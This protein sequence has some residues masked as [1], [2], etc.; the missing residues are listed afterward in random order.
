[1]SIEYCIPQELFSPKT[2]MNIL[3]AVLKFLQGFRTSPARDAEIPKRVKE[4]PAWVFL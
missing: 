2:K 1:M 4:N 3:Q